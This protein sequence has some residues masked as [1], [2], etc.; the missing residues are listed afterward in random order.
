VPAVLAACSA[1]DLIADSMVFSSMVARLGMVPV[2]YVVVV[3]VVVVVMM[4]VIFVVVGMTNFVVMTMICT[5]ISGTQ[6]SD[7]S[8]HPDGEGHT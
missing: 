7:P 4:F 6:T 5:F 1:P 3:V 2:M 8:Q